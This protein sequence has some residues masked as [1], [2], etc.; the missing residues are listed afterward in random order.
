M[1]SIRE[2][3]D[4]LEDL[5]DLLERSVNPDAPIVITEG[6]II[7]Q[8]FSPVLD[9]YREAQTSGKQWILDIEARERDATGI[10]N[11]RVQYN[12]VFGYYIEVT[13]SFLSL[14]P[15]RY[16]RKQ[17]L[18]NAERFMTPELKE[19]EQK[20]IGA[21]E[22]SIRLELQLFSEIRDRVAE[23][24]SSIQQTAYALK[25]LDAYQS[26]SRTASESRY[27]RPVMNA[28]G[29]LSITEGRHPVVERNM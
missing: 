12:K 8:G 3:L 28:D 21:Q 14:V 6:G 26:L 25:K 17:T 5:T 20:I 15:E 16:I 18:T 19:V 29:T 24:I 1:I 7:R 27:V 11:L 22:Q 10:R 23:R 9:E 2:E 13:K 4:P